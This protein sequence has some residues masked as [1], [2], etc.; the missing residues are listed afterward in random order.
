MRIQPAGVSAASEPASA[1]FSKVICASRK[2]PAAV[3]DGVLMLMLDAASPN[4]GVVIPVVTPPEATRETLAADRTATAP[5]EVGDGRLSPHP[6]TATAKS[7][8][9]RVAR[10]LGLNARLFFFISK[11]PRLSGALAASRTAGA[12]SKRWTVRQAPDGGNGSEVARV[13]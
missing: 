1:P 13:G 11:T 2:S 7:R 6:A 3:L 4:V 10:S 9:A 5:G 12:L 8:A